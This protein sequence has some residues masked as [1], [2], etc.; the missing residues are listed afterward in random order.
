MSQKARFPI[1]TVICKI[2]TNNK[3]YLDK[4]TNWGV[5]LI[6]QNVV[7]KDLTL[8]IQKDTKKFHTL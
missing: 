5:V 4:I 3:L 2:I 6:E 8:T 7:E 1:H